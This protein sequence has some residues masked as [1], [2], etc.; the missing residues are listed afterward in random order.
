MTS[1]KDKKIIIATHYLLYGAAQAFRDYLNSKKINTLLYIAL[2]LVTQRNAYFISYEKGK[3]MSEKIINRGKAIPVFDYFI[4]FLQ[5]VWFVSVQQP[6]TNPLLKGEGT[7]YIGV[8]GL[9]CLAGLLLKKFGKVKKVIFYSIDFVPIRFPNK[10]LNAIYHNIEIFCVKHADEC[11]NVSPRI[12]EGRETFLHLSQKEYAQKVVPIGIWNKDIKKRPFHQIKKHQVLFIGHLLEKQGVQMVLE[13]IPLIIKKVPDFT[14]IIVG[15][16]E[17][18]ERLKQLVATLHIAKYVEFTG[19]IKDRKK[20]DEMMSKSAIAVATYKPEK[21]KLYNFTYYA[22]PTKLKD[23]LGA[24]LPIVL[25]DISYNAQEIAEKKCGILVEY[26]KSD[27]A[28]AIITLLQ[29][30]TQLKKYRKNALEYAQSF[31]WEKIFDKIR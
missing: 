7:V 5:T 19:W 14:F 25:T 26:T 13:A 11:W 6:H 3:Q 8:D 4:D 10:L 22:D 2:P 12:A 9:N 28:K 18:E 1:L 17:Y 30:E 23:Y 24:G 16:G 29:E 21:E 15:G 27:I 20:I 31:D